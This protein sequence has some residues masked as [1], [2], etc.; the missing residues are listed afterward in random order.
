MFLL[1]STFSSNSA[2]NSH[3]CRLVCR[4]EPPKS[5]A[6]LKIMQPLP[7]KGKARAYQVP[8]DFAKTMQPL[9][10][11]RKAC[12]YEVLPAA[13]VKVKSAADEAAATHLAEVTVRT[14]VVAALNAQ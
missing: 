2:C 3:G 14:S 4:L 11:K 8:A 6:G 10:V 13:F 5:A 12:A 1:S 7:V 9:P